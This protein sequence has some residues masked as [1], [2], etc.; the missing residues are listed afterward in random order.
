MRSLISVLQL[1]AA[2]TAAAWVGVME[3]DRPH[4]ATESVRVAAPPPVTTPAVA[5]ATL[6]SNAAVDGTVAAPLQPAPAP[7]RRV[8]VVRRSRA[9]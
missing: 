6:L 1:T 2:A 5:A 7:T 4:L 8:I 9:S 3:A